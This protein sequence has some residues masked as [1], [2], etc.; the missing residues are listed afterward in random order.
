M[1]NRDC[2]YAV[3]YI[4]L[5]RAAWKYVVEL[6]KERKDKCTVRVAYHERNKLAV[7]YKLGSTYTYTSHTLGPRD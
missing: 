3:T 5:L 1:N 6:L 2:E 7:L 4:R